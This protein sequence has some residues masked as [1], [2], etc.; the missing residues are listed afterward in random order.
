MSE[1]LFQAHGQSSA[2][3]AHTRGPWD[4]RSQHGGAPAALLAREIER[5]EPGAAMVVA[6]I[7]Y[8]FLGAVPIE[9]L[10]VNAQVVRPGRRLQLVEAELCAGGRPVVRA[11]AVRLR[12]AD[13]DLPE[14]ARAP[15]G[16]PDPGPQTATPEPFPADTGDEGFSRTGLEIRWSSGSYA[17]PGPARAWFRFARRL[18]GD[19][20][21]S[22]LQTT[23]AAAD[24]GN[25]ISRVLGFDSHLFV[26]TDL[27]VL[28]H[29]APHGEWVML[30]SVTVID[31]IGAGTARSD[32]YDIAGAVG[33][34]AQTLFVEERA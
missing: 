6:R 21:V 17:E 25:G 7:T 32:L 33:L 20:P 14:I 4:A 18:V 3:S 8:E 16:L 24:F 15:A 10:T 26:N 30:D 28:L 22:A 12:R 11:R 19:E 34:G 2:P 13:I 23:V 9:P 29:R 1:P 31:P 27:T 5:L